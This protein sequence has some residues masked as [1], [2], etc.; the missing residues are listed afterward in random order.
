M[1]FLGPI[2]RG[3]KFRGVSFSF[4]EKLVSPGNRRFHAPIDGPLALATLNVGARELRCD[5]NCTA[6]Y[7]VVRYSRSS[8]KEYSISRRV[9]LAECINV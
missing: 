7:S 4:K 6:V 8:S 9:E 1:K 5:R 3:K 2:S